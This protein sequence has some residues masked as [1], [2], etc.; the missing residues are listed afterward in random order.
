MKIADILHYEA[1]LCKFMD[2]QVIF[3][4]LFH[5][6]AATYKKMGDSLQSSSMESGQED[7]LKAEQ[8][9]HRKRERSYEDGYCTKK[10]KRPPPT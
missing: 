6:Y 3:I 8:N 2:G 1:H 4:G 9:E 7:A 10:Q 5:M